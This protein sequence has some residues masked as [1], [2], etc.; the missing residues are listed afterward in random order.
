MNQS[1]PVW[2][3]GVGTR[4]ECGNLCRAE[5]GSPALREE[6]GGGQGLSAEG[7]ARTEPGEQCQAVSELGQRA[8]GDSAWQ[9]AGPRMPGEPLPCP[10]HLAAAWWGAPRPP[11]PPSH[12]VSCSSKPPG[13]RLLPIGRRRLLRPDLSASHRPQLVARPWTAGR[14]VL[15]KALGTRFL[16]SILFLDTTGEGDSR[17]S[18]YSQPSPWKGLAPYMSLFC[19]D[20]LSLQCSMG[21]AAMGLPPPGSPPHMPPSCV[22]PPHSP[23]A[24]PEVQGAV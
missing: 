7:P 11:H 13:E 20:D 15:A 18:G 6:R 3:R 16:S 10:S 17:G 8:G 9:M 22:D 14:R 12:P 21:A 24:A 4:H 1:R 5:R 19:R 23:P 2:A